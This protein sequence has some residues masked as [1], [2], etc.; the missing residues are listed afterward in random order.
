MCVCIASLLMHSLSLTHIHTHRTS[1][2]FL[3]K[4]IFIFE[5]SKVYF[6][7]DEKTKTHFTLSQ[8]FT[9]KITFHNMKAVTGTGDLHEGCQ[10]LSL[11]QQF[12]RFMCVETFLEGTSADILAVH[13]NVSDRRSFISQ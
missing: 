1:K 12:S 8:S 2:Q 13:C 7:I 9:Q 4:F 6:C 3:L 10:S 5:L 11:L